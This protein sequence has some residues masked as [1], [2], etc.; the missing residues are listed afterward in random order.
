MFDRP[1]LQ[2]WNTTDDEEIALR[3][4]RGTTE[5]VAIEAFEADHPVFGTF[6]TRSETGGSYEVEIRDL[7]G[8]SN[9][10][11]CIDHRVNGLGT[12]KHVEGVL[13]ALRR[14]GAKA[15][16]AAAA[17]GPTRVEIF[18]RSPRHTAPR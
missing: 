15:F 1:A 2:G 9:S 7:K 5:I 4:W 17:V 12:C 3:R 10:C 16:R 14:R 11:G 6:R 8:F 13:A 18:P